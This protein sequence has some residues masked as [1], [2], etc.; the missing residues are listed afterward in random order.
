MRLSRSPS[1]WEDGGVLFEL[2]LLLR[3]EGSLPFRVTPTAGSQA[4]LRTSPATLAQSSVLEAD[5]V[6]HCVADKGYKFIAC[7]PS[8]FAQQVSFELMQIA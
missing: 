3:V 4:E 1:C 5:K 6:D 2:A 8:G 7:L